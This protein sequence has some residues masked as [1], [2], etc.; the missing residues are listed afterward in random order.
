M[1]DR[2]N[3][4]TRQNG[5]ILLKYLIQQ[6]LLWVLKLVPIPTTEF[7]HRDNPNLHEP[8]RLL[9]RND[10]TFPGKTDILFTWS[11]KTLISVWLRKESHTHLGWP[12]VSK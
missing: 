8:S 12:V 9:W 6:I 5:T 1:I 7:W 4:W 2:Y 11:S 3:Q 10:Q